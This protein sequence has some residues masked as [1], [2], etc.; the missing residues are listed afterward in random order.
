MMN[1]FC[2]LL[3]AVFAIMICVSCSEQVNRAELQNEQEIE[4]ISFSSLTKKNLYKWIDKNIYNPKEFKV[5]SIEEAWNT[6]S[7]CILNVTVYGEN[8]FGGHFEDNIQYL[9]IIIDGAVYEWCDTNVHKDGVLSSVKDPYK[10]EYMER[11]QDPTLMKIEEDYSNEGLIF[12]NA[13]VNA[14]RDIS[15]AKMFESGQIA[16]YQ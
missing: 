12:R 10:L 9:N 4:N 6:D 11:K 13:Y 14:C 5:K 1:K 16:F 7:L 3:V 2:I 15:G 8:T